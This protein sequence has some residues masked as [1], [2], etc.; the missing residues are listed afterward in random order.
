MKQIGSPSDWLGFIDSQV[1]A[2]LNMV[3]DTWDELPSPCCDE[4]EDVITK[5]FAS[6]LKR[7]RARCELPFR[8]DTQLV[9]LEPAAG[10]DEGRMD[11]VFSPP[12]SR[13]DIY[14][15]F[16]CKRINVPSA[17]GVRPYFAE[18]VVQGMLRFT[19]GQYGRRVKHGGMLAYVLNG[20]VAAAIS[21]VEANFPPHANELGMLSLAKFSMSS[22][23]PDDHRLRETVHARSS[24]LSSFV[25][26]HLFLP[27][28]PDAPFR[29]EN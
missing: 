28:D 6:A 9:E 16:E 27:G 24:G 17:K 19:R 1:P 4:R 29:A 2:I 7:S 14:F 3:M 10:E 22:V 18:Y 20:D 15:C 5:A 21:G 11:I 12:V 25:I 26:S 23:F 8:I 13:E